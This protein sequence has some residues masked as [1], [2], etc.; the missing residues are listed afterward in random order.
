M[1]SRDPPPYESPKVTYT[2][3]PSTHDTLITCTTS[4]SQPSYHIPSPLTTRL[5]ELT[6][7]G[8]IP[9]RS[10]SSSSSLPRYRDVCKIT[11]LPFVGFLLASGNIRAQYH[12]SNNAF[13]KRPK[14]RGSVFLKTPL[15]NLRTGM[16]KPAL[17][18]KHDTIEDAATGEL[19]VR[20]FAYKTSD[21]EVRAMG[22][23][24][25]TGTMRV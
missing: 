19:L 21:G 5:N 13:K 7:S 10:S 2:I 24:T 17:K 12:L 20:G 22:W 4:A 23:Q 1:P 11:R 15:G 6:I 8:A 25:V 9:S 18:V 3:R 16:D 14:E